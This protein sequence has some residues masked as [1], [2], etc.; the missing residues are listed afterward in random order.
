MVKLVDPSV[1]HDLHDVAASEEG[2]LQ[3]LPWQTDH[4]PLL[5]GEATAPIVPLTCPLALTPMPGFV[6]RVRRRWALQ[7]VE[8]QFRL[9]DVFNV[10]RVL[11]E[12][13]RYRSASSPWALNSTSAVPARNSCTRASVT[14]LTSFISITIA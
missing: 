9:Q 1:R 11:L 2:K 5:I 14:C 8:R 12:I 7:V 6:P 3:I 10:Q 4:I 13:Q